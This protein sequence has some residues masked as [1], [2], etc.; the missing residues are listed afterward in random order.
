M[1]T[2]LSKK[3]PAAAGKGGG[4]LK[5]PACD[6]KK[7]PVT[8]VVA[9]LSKGVS[10]LASG[11][12]KGKASKDDGEND[13]DDDEEEAEEGSEENADSSKRD[14]GK[15]IKFAAMKAKLPQHIVDLYDKESANHASPRSFK[16]LIINKLFKKLPSGRFQLCTNDPMFVEA[17]TL[18]EKKYSNDKEKSLPKSIMR[19]LYFQGSE[20]AFQD[21]VNAGDIY[22][23]TNE[24]D[25]KEYWSFN[26]KETGKQRQAF[27]LKKTKSVLWKGVLCTYDRKNQLSCCSRCFLHCPIW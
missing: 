11:S 5:R 21:A 24:E 4:T 22:S 18:F 17:K 7:G 1:P 9:A 12:K 26:S 15:A 25:G 13:D 16:T 8:S 2:V 19:G 14:K 27:Y 3:R 6:T 23:W 10:G 20:A